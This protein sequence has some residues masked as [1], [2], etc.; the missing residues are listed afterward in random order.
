MPGRVVIAFILSGIFVAGC[1]DPQPQ[2]KQ[3]PNSPLG[4]LTKEEFLEGVAE[5]KKEAAES[6]IPLAKIVLPNVEGWVR[7]EPKALH[8]VDVGFTVAYDHPR[9]IA[10]TLYQ[11][12]RG[13]TLISD[14]LTN[15][16]AVEEMEH[17]KTGIQQ[18]VELGVWKA[19]DE[20]NAGIVK[21]GVSDQQALWTR[22]DLTV[23][24][25]TGVSD[26]YVWVR[27]NAVFK[28]RITSRY[29]N[30]DVGDEMLQPLL[31]AIGNAAEVVAAE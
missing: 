7:S 14:D 12:T 10:V 20:T 19:A 26:I 16:K 11:Y 6:E 29:T 9:G 17:A 22:Y 25:G 27:S 4:G 5:I 2:E 31:T 18:A 8:P 1:S 24:S 13:L 28:L 21:L 30:A 15:G 23:D 3:S